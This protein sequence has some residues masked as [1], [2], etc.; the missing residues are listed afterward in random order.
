MGFYNILNIHEIFVSRNVCLKRISDKSDHSKMVLFVHNSFNFV[1][2]F[3]KQ[4]HINNLE[5]VALTNTLKAE[6]HLDILEAVP[7]I[8]IP[9]VEYHL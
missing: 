7:Y 6:P 4:C 8:N 5:A 3:L 2:M 9:E 1:Q